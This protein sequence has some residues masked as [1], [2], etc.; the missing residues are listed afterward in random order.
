MCA[1]GPRTSPT[2]RSESPRCDASQTE[3]TTLGRSEGGTDVARHRDDPPPDEPVEPCAERREC[4][5]R[6]PERVSRT[7]HPRDVGDGCEA[8][9][10]CGELAPGDRSFGVPE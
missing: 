5:E 10:A 3:S 4:V 9:L 1:F 2:T 8:E 6:D 7:Q